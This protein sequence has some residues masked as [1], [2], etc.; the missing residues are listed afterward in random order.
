LSHTSTNTR[1][2]TPNIHIFAYYPIFAHTI[3]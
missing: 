2:H 1:I 3:Y